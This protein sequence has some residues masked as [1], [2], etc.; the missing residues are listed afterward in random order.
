LRIE[1][2][3]FSRRHCWIEIAPPQAKVMNVRSHNGKF[4]NSERMTS[5]WLKHGDVISGGQTTI[6]VSI[7][8]E[9]SKSC[10]VT[11]DTSSILALGQGTKSK[12]IT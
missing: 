10:D 5:A 2:Q 11:H 3:H 1:G 7:S 6:A 8:S 4:V 12:R 9:T